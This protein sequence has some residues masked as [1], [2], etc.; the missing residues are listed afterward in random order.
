MP[1]S[2]SVKIPKMITTAQNPDALNGRRKSSGISS[3]KKSVI[4]DGKKGLVQPRSWK[5]LKEKEAG[6]TRR[7]LHR[8]WK[9]ETKEGNED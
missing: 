6:L 9:S 2:F 7:L 1:A 4:T 8:K 5:K 3:G